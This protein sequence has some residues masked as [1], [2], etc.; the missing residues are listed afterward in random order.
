M[1]LVSPDL[2][3]SFVK[4]AIKSSPK[5]GKNLQKVATRSLSQSFRK[6]F[7]DFARMYPDPKFVYCDPVSRNLEAWAKSTT[8][9]RLQL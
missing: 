3:L 9:L 1:R 8:F 6:A 4:V 2:D 7:G 5:D